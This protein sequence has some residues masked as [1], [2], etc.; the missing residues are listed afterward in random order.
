MKLTVFERLALLN[1]LPERGSLA[2]LRILRDLASDLSFTEQ[3]HAA[4]G[5]HENE[6]GLEWDTE[7]EPVDVEI[8]DRAQALIRDQFEQLSEAGALHQ[9]LLPI[10]ERFLE[11]Q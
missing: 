3:E 5:F 1:N 9:S 4:I 8:G 7:P 10:A 2:D 6:S 11:E